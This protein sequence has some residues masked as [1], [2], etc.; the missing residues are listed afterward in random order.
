MHILSSSNYDAWFCWASESGTVLWYHIGRCFGLFSA[1]SFCS[2]FSHCIIC[3]DSASHLH[4]TLHTTHRILDTSNTINE[5]VNW[6]YKNSITYQVKNYLI[7][8]SYLISLQTWSKL[9]NQS[10]PVRTYIHAS[11]PTWP[12]KSWPSSNSQ[13]THVSPNVPKI[14]L[15]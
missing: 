1:F 9:P 4:F 3:I 5:K 8:A 10:P 14:V 7:T 13:P 2:L 15:P 11:L 12:Y 6:K